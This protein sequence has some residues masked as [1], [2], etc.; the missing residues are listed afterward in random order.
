MLVSEYFPAWFLGRNPD[1]RLITAS[2][3]QELASDFGRKVRNQL[4]DPLFQDIFPGAKLS[5]DSAAIDKFNLAAPKT[6]GYFAVGV[7]G[8]MTGRGA[9]CIIVDDPT[10]N[11]ED[12]DSES[13][14]RR[15]KDWFTAVAYTRLMG[16]G[17]IIVCQTRWN[18]D[19]LAGWL[20][21][22]QK[23]ENWTVLNLP[24]INEK[25]EALWPERFPLSIL[26]S[27]KRTLPLR[28]WEAL[29]Q[30]KP[31]IEEGEIFKRGW[32]KK[33]PDHQ[34]LP[35]CKYI[36]QSWDTA[37][38][39]QDIK[40]NSYSARTTWGVFQRPDDDYVNVIL[41]EAWKGRIDYSDLRKEA[42]LAYREY[43]PD[44]VIIEKKASGM[45]LVQ[46]LRRAGLPIHAFN[47]ERDKFARAYRAQ[48]LFEDGR[49]YYPDRKWADD[50]IDELCTF[51]PGNP[52]DTADTIS[53]A[54]IWLT[55]SWM[56][57]PSADIEDDEDELPDNVSRLLPRKK[58][59]YA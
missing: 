1:K 51:R 31:F 34:P 27:I 48:A 44:K 50:V 26:Q 55:K 19:D 42:L 30:Q 4:V 20:Q 33:W 18:L 7:G 38:T 8:A 14:R 40:S 16:D 3:G 35:D 10:K 36:V 17:A 22:D 41:L 23:H 25:G 32:W 29:Y 49:V 56:I 52:N 54:F 57:Q 13:Y 45:S 28:D 6:G 43:E 5:D 11:R 58:A 46:D 21:R 39:E 9:H 12:S 24:A 15:L 53:Q 37:Y 59:V 2:Y 47:P